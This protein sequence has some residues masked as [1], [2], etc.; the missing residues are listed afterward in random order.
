MFEP[1]MLGRARFMR[2]WCENYRKRLALLGGEMRGDACV[3]CCVTHHVGTVQESLVCERACHLHL[4]VDASRKES[5]RLR[6][7]FRRS[8]SDF[9]T[10][11][12]FLSLE[13][14]WRRGNVF[15]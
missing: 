10:L 7:T 8:L 9:R 13:L 12:G 3:C 14:S 1:C 15:V 11:C 5:T 4:M 6:S 2:G